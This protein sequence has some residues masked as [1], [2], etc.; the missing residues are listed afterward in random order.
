[1]PVGVIALQGGCASISSATLR[2]RSLDTGNGGSL[3]AMLQPWSD[4]ATWNSLVNGIQAD[5]VEASSAADDSIGANSVSDVDLDVTARVQDWVDGTKENNGWAVLPNG[6]DGWDIASAERGTANYRPEL[7]VTFV[8]GA[9]I[10]TAHNPSPVSGASGV[11]VSTQLQWTPGTGALRH[12]V[13]LWTGSTPVCVSEW[14]EAATYTPVLASDT[15]YS[16]RIDD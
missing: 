9:P 6:V 8:P 16:W 12:D 15:T 14:Q 2:L 13:Y 11:P 1:M 5:D 3:H 7:I 4:A 10:D